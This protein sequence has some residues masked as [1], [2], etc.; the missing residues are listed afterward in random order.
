[1]SVVR[2][3]EVSVMILEVITGMQE[4]DTIIMI[5]KTLMVDMK[6]IM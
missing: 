1:M 5:E 3:E 6:K 4:K 2:R